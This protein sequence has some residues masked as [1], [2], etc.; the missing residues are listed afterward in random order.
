M[1]PVSTQVLELPIN[2][3]PYSMLTL[4]PGVIPDGNSGT[5][6]IVNGGR[7]NTTAILMDGQDTRNN[8]TLDNAYTPPQESVKNTVHHQ[9]LLGRIRP[10]QRRHSGG[11]RQDRHQPGAR[12]RLRLPEQRRP[13]CQ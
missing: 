5:G 7:S 3:N 9:Q 2:R 10:F 13:E 12:Q 6:P 11:S 1:L 8:S 4:S